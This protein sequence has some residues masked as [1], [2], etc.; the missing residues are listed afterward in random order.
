[1]SSE[2]VILLVTSSCC[3]ILFLILLSLRKDLRSAR[4]E[5]EDAQIEIIRKN[6][7]LEVIRNVEKELKASRRKN[8]PQKVDAPASG[9]STSRVDRLNR[10]SDSTD[11]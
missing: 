11:K 9:D 6:N 8:A 7:E 2:S 3:A 1:M 4:K 5:L 10:L